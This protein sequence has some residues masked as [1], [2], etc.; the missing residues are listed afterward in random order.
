M[1]AL[2]AAFKWGNVA[3]GRIPTGLQQTCHRSV[4]RKVCPSYRVLI[5]YAAANEHVLPSIWRLRAPCS[6][7]SDIDSGQQWKR[8]LL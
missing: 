3:S 8:C 4:S 7:Y 5:G 6:Q 2:K 1:L